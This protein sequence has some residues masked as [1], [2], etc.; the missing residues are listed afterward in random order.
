MIALVCNI[1]S[2]EPQAIHRTALGLSGRKLEIDGKD[3]MALGGIKGGAVKL[4]ADEDVSYALGIAEG[5]E[6]ALSLQR[7]P[8]WQGLP[9]WSLLYAE[10]VEI[11]PVLPGI[12]TLV[13]AVD[14]DPAGELAALVVAQRWRA[15]GREVRLIEA[16]KANNDL[17]DVVARP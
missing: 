10:G 1:I 6:T 7:L 15:A 13:I 8:E 14:H 11:F 9:V 12:E 17:N 2:N 3:R 4:S 5:I 16:I